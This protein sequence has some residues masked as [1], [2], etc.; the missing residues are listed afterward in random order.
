MDDPN[1]IIYKKLCNLDTFDFICSIVKRLGLI[2]LIVEQLF[3]CNKV[4]IYGK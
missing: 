3:M 4:K 1:K 2:S